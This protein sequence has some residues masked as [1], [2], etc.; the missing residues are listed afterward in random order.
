MVDTAGVAAVLRPMAGGR[1]RVV[2][3]GNFATP[4][5]TLR[6]IDAALPEYRLFALNAQ[7]GMPERAG[8]VHETPFVGP[9]VR[10]SAHLDYVPARLSLVPRLFAR[11]HAPDVVVLHTTPPRAGRV[12]M[13]VEVNILPAA[14]EAVRRRGGLVIAQVNPRM[15]WTYGDGELSTDQ[16]DLGVEVDEQLA[17]PVP[18][19]PG[20]VER[21][22]G[23]R[24]AAFVEDGAT[25]QLG[26]GGVP[27]ATLTALVGRR[28]LRV[29]TE[30]FSDG[31][32]AL[33]EAGALDPDEQLVASFVFGSPELY[34][35]VDGNP[36]VRMLRTEI[37]NDPA[38]IARHPRMTSVNSALQVDLFGQA[39]ASWAGGRIY[40]GF[41]GQSDF[42]VGALH[43][44]GG[45]AVVALPSWH[46]KADRS[47]IVA[48]LDGPATSFQHS[49]VVT[50][51]GA[52]SIWPATSRDQ[53][54]NL[55]QVAHPDARAEL[56]RE[57]TS[58]GLLA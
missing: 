21:M 54:R 39:N 12:S 53:A 52:A 28:G 4:H 48:G 10:R 14:V 22:I 51:Q 36:R 7:A 18:R 8:V 1:P 42:V 40:S 56:Q 3:P 41:G 31:V 49:W 23:E 37:T 55:I 6:V 43:A 25:L 47:T 17:S 30:M 38:E 27:D 26:I 20:D 16:I 5:A 2:V 44:A 19:A 15:P 32:L 45:I 11:T 46:P 29:W 58:R 57:A 50:E 9:G 35:W 24:V 34:K 33:D 13:G